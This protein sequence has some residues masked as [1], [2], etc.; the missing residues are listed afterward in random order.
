MKMEYKVKS[1]NGQGLMNSETYTDLTTDNLEEAIDDAASREYHDGW[2]KYVWVE[3]E[4]GNQV[5]P[6]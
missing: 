5:W 6:K 2:N 1:I 4:D 3:D